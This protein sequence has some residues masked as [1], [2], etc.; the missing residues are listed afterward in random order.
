[1]KIGL[2]KPRPTGMPEPNHGDR[3]E[4]WPTTGSD[5]TGMAIHNVI[6]NAVKDP[7]PTWASGSFGCGL[8]MTGKNGSIRAI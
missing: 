1:M 4:K 7:S 3:H 8:R 2:S 6:L 5:S